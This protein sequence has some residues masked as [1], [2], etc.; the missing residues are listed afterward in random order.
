M[1]FLSTSWNN[2][3]ALAAASAAL[4]LLLRDGANGL[5]T[6]PS[7]VDGAKGLAVVLCGFGG[8]AVGSENGD[9]GGGAPCAGGGWYKASLGA[10]YV[11]GVYMGGWNEL[12]GGSFVGEEARNGFIGAEEFPLTPRAPRPREP[13]SCE[14]AK[15]GGA[16]EKG[17]IVAVVAFDVPK[18]LAAG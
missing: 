12:G 17:L 5:A 9:N 18:V 7:L 13:E 10:V 11:E 8:C 4:L 14:A 6:V 2:W 15:G 3:R 16:A 1:L